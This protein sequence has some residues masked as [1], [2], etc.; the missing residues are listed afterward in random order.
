M[1]TESLLSSKHQARGLSEHIGIMLN[2]VD[3]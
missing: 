2:N 3:E 1:L